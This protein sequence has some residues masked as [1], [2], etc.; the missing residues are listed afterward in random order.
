MKET[1]TVK[2]MPIGGIIL[3]AGNSKKYKTG[4][5][6]AFRPVWKK[7]KCV[8]C[9]ICV[10]FCPDNCIKHNKDSRQEEDLNYCKGCGICADVCPVKCISMKE[11]AKFKK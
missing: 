11:E 9:M 7:E 2:Q 3:E 10:Q 4:S 8:H 1:R 6:R 5:W